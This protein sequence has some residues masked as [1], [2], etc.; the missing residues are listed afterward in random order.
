MAVGSGRRSANS[1]PEPLGTAGTP[2]DQGDAFDHALDGGGDSVTIT[3]D[4]A[5]SVDYFCRL[6]PTM[7]GTITVGCSAP[8]HPAEPHHP[9]M[10][11]VWTGS[12]D[13]MPVR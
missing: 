6:H 7:T 11:H 9:G 10:S 2:D 3:F 5:G 13:R 8:E 12:L 1:S 4:E